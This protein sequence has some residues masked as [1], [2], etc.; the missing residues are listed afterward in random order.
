V[1]VVRGGP[2]LLLDPA[3]AQREVAVK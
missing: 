1:L 3:A 2:E